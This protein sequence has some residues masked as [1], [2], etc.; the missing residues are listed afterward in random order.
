ML[1]YWI[2]SLV[3]EISWVIFRVSIFINLLRQKNQIYLI[4]FLCYIFCSDFIRSHRSSESQYFSNCFFFIE[5]YCYTRF[6]SSL[7][8]ISQ[9]IFKIS[10]Q[11]NKMYCIIIILYSTVCSDSRSQ[12]SSLYQYL[13]SC[14]L[15]LST[16]I[17]RFHKSFMLSITTILKIFLKPRRSYRSY[18]D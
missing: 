4:I 11:K 8:E 10:R 16:A 5:I 6:F 14:Y 12:R 7:C 15:I 2:I 18:R 9:V 13:S 17:L 1:L 3:Y